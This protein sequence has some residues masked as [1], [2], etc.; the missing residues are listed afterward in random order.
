MQNILPQ[1]CVRSNKWLFKELPSNLIR[2]GDG[3]L[4]IEI[5]RKCLFVQRGQTCT[6]PSPGFKEGSLWALGLHLYHVQ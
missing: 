2:P 1:E 5:P 3:K 6:N 4:F